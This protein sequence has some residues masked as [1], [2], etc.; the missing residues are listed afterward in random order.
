MINREEEK[1]KLEV[2]IKDFI[3]K[4]T[5][6]AKTSTATIVWKDIE[7][8]GDKTIMLKVPI[9]VLPSAAAIEIAQMA[10]K[11]LAEAGILV[12]LDSATYRN[13]KGF[14]GP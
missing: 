7:R 14:F 2:Q 5:G 3:T 6:G 9:Y 8:T 12:H 10:M 13:V 4:N 11:E 1:K